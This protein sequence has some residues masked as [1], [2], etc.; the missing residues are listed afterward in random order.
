MDKTNARE[1]AREYIIFLKNNNFNIEKAYLFGSHA[2]GRDTEN[3]DIDLAVV[4]REL[5]DSFDM[6]VQLMKLRRKIDTRIEPHPFL[7]SDFDDSNPLVHEIL[8][9]GLEIDA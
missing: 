5:E 9:T 7:E 3:S 6:Q 4:F 2:K 1:I 8:D